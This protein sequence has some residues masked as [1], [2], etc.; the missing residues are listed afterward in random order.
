[1]RRL[2]ALAPIV[3]LATTL[4]CS[5]M[6]T[7][8]RAMVTVTGQ[9]I[10]R[11]G[12]GIEQVYIQ[13]YSLDPRD[14]VPGPI[15]P[16]VASGAL[17]GPSAP[18]SP[19]ANGST[20]TDGNG[21][22]RITLAAGRYRVFLD[23]T[24]GYPFVELPT[25]DIRPGHPEVNYRY[26]GVRISGTLQGPAGATIQEGRVAV[27]R[28]PEGDG[29]F[30][31]AQSDL[32]SGRYSILVPPGTYRLLASPS[33]MGI[34][35]PTLRIEPLVVASDTTLDLTLDGHLVTGTVRGQNGAPLDRISI[36][37]DSYTNLVSTFSRSDGTYAMYLP[38]DVYTM[39]LRPWDAHFIASRE[40]PPVSVTGPMTLDFDMSG[41]EWTGTVRWT[42]DSSAVADA[43]VGVSE[44]GKY[45]G[46]SA[47]TD[48]SGQ[49]RLIVK[50]NTYYRLFVGYS[51]G[52][53]EIGNVATTADS[54]FNLYVE[55]PLPTPAL[56]AAP[57]APA[58]AAEG[59][60]FRRRS[61]RTAE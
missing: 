51:G 41:V 40:Y 13:F 58:S 24:R 43:Y 15:Y 31:A 59:R 16:E 21:R 12:P 9:I 52:A 32:L 29:D 53:E 44:I 36:R 22:Y 35:F 5:E 38:T 27:F 60:A 33:Y 18:R 19:S 3:A 37:A 26:T 7:A 6:P 34:G 25:I 39:Q 23:P 30:T 45:F 11:D 56:Q 48:A 20:V 55:G 1:M 61:S 10:D 4:S 50:P 28:L 14:N 8:P 49:F 54:T 2:F 57:S 46:A 17:L 42:L 47:H